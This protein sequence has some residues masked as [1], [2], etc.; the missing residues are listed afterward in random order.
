M[1]ESNVCQTDSKCE[2]MVTTW[3]TH[4]ANNNTYLGIKVARQE[5]M[6]RYVHTR[7]YCTWL[8]CEEGTCPPVN[9][10]D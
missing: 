8:Y 1:F 5:Q 7:T 3:F 9:N 6:Q 10:N 2:D 4:C